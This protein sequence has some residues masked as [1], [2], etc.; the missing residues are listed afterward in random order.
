MRIADVTHCSQPGKHGDVCM[1]GKDGWGMLLWSTTVHIGLL[2]FISGAFSY[3]VVSFHIMLGGLGTGTHPLLSS[4]L[5]YPCS[6]HNILQV[7][8]LPDNYEVV[9]RS[10]DDVRYVLNPRFQPADVARLDKVQ[11]EDM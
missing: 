6:L 2:V 9:D 3:H 8:C 11:C 1:F 4:L 10:L 5:R 7:Y